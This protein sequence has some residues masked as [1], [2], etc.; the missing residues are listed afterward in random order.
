MQKIEKILKKSIRKYKIEDKVKT[1]EVLSHWEKIISQILPETKG[2]TMAVSFERGVLRIAALS[3]ESADLINLLQ[4]RIIYAL[5]NTLGK[6]LVF[7]I[8]CEC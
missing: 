2:K 1:Y 7:R 6:T 8:Y 4:K 3:H 5:N